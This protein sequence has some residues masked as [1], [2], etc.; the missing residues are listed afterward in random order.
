MLRA[1]H[2]ALCAFLTGAAFGQTL[3]KD[4]NPTFVNGNGLSSTT[5][6][7]L[8]VGSVAYFAANDGVNGIELWRSD[9][10][11]AGTVLLK[12]INVTALG[13]SSSPANFAAYGAGFVFS[14][15][16]G[17]TG[18]E[19]WKS[20]GTTA[21][22]VLA[23]DIYPGANTSSS[24]S[25]FTVLGA[26]VYFA[27]TDSTATTGT[28]R[29]LYR[30]DGTAAT[31]VK[32]LYVGT[33]S[34]ISGTGNMVAVGP[35]LFLAGNDGTNG[36]ELWKSDGTNAGTLLVANINT[37]AAASSSPALLTPFG[38][39]VIFNA[40]DGLTG[41]EPWVSD[42]TAAGTVLLLD[43]APTTLSSSPAIYTPAGARVFFTAFDGTATTGTGRELYVTDGTPAGTKLVIDLYAGTLS[44]CS[45][46]GL[47][48]VGS[49]VLFAGQTL[50]TGSE[51]WISDGTAAGTT[52]YADFW[53]GAGNG[54]PAP[55]YAFGGK[56]YA[57]ATDGSFSGGNFELMVTDGTAAGT[58]LIKDIW[59]GGQAGDPQSFFTLGGGLYFLANE[60]NN[61]GIELWT[62]DGTTAGT[63]LVK[64]INPVGSTAAS[65][66]PGVMVKFGDKAYFGANNGSLG[67]ELWETDGTSAGT[68]LLKD[69]NTAGTGNSSSPANM[70]VHGSKMYF[71]AND[72]VNGIELWVTDGTSAGTVMLKDI[73][74]TAPGASA[75]PANLTPVG[76]TLFFTA[77]DGLN[78]VELWSSDGTSAGT[79]MVKDLNAGTLSSSPSLLTRLG[80]RVVFRAT[81][82]AAS[83]IEPWVSDGTAAGTVLLKDI[84]PGTSS[85]SPVNL[86]VAGAKLFFV[87]S[88]STAT[89][90]TGTELYVTDGTPA[91][92]QLLEVQAGT[93]SGATTSALTLVALGN[94]VLFSGNNGTA[95]NGAELWFSD[96]TIPGTVL[97]KDIN[98]G[99]A[100]AS[101]ANMTRL[102]SKVLFNATNGTSGIEPFVT[103]GTNAGTVLLGDL[104]PLTGSSSPTAY[105]V[106]GNGAFFTAFD[107]TATT[108]TGRE[109][110]LTDGTPAGTALVKDIFP[111]TSSGCSAS[112]VAVGMGKTIVVN[113][114]DGVAGTE[115]WT[116]NGTGAGTTLLGD[117]NPGSTVGGGATNFMVVG[118]NLVYSAT[119]GT[120]VTANPLAVGT[121]LWSVSLTSL[122]ASEAATFGTSCQG[123]GTPTIGVSGGAPYIGNAAFSVDLS[124]A[125]ASA[126]TLLFLNNSRGDLPIGPCTIYPSL[127]PAISFGTS[128]NAS[129]AAATGVSI[130]PGPWNIG[131]QL[132]FQYVIVDAG[133]PILG[134]AS[135]S[136]GLRIRIGGS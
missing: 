51:G 64:D 80:N 30:Y 84:Y 58:K 113:A 92:T 116:S 122:G 128:T 6:P 43:C 79:T 67:V 48:A 52:L 77:N 28:G 117:L 26:N 111:G 65:S 18:I 9:G 100:S 21:G 22:T 24:P 126:P 134:L 7:V 97:V 83:G 88:N 73:N 55:F 110:Y 4:I 74:T 31:L 87:A 35:T 38:A 40:N 129:G 10:T 104:Y 47:L 53:P 34:G 56:H 127:S 107:G 119:N 49:N 118:D 54:F 16:D 96:G 125:A 2:L 112:P 106:A 8:V 60:G 61:T 86:T 25:G 76:N 68:K 108:G 124:N 36:I 130:P 46:I 32:D 11:A 102:G 66:S 41:I 57:N 12:D 75:S 42:G 39:N 27:A 50:A 101:P 85:S 131:I 99:T 93:G 98:V 62:S 23:A 14:A 17:V 72:G 29:E 5:S 120:S 105:V 133:G 78:G 132:Y 20:D 114:N 59:P 63:V 90:G 45:T 19:V 121:E 3:V 91:G 82:S 115:L 103:D 135:S 1:T 44:G 95:V 33:S 13:A 69:I 94:G 109:L 71:S 89:T 70:T 136:N 37:A 81:D 15:T 123:T